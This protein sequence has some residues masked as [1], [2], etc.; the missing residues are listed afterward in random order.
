M[1]IF[2][3]LW[4]AWESTNILNNMARPFLAI[5]NNL[6][7]FSFEPKLLFWSDGVVGV[8][9]VVGEFRNKTKLQP[10]AV[11]VE[12]LLRLA[13]RLMFGIISFFDITG[14]LSTSA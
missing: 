6:D 2:H 5:W 11:E 7:F 8:G 10:S 9:G 4:G 14:Y 13:I 12:L 3:F 1:K